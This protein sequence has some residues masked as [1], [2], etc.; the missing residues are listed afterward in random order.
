[1]NIIVVGIGNVGE[2]ITEQLAKE[3]HNLVVVDKDP[4]I[5]NRTVEDYDVKGVYGN[6]A[7]Y[8]VL[9][10]A[11][12]SSADLLV[13]CTQYDEMNI[14]SCLVAK[15]LGVKE[16]IA[17]I[18]NS[19][20]FTLFMSAE[21]GINMM[22]SPEYQVAKE[23]ARLLRFPS[24]IKIEPFAGGKV[25]L[26]ELRIKPESPLNGVALH[27]LHSKLDLDVLVCAVM[28]QND[29]FIPSGNFTLLAGDRI[30]VTAS[31]KILNKFFTSLGLLKGSKKVMVIGG[32]RTASFLATELEK[33]DMRVKII[34]KDE[35]KCAR[36]TD[37]LRKTEVVL[38][39]G[40]DW[41][42]LEDE[43]VKSADA[44]VCLC[45]LDEQNVIMSLLIASANVG[46]VIAKVEK[47]TYYGMLTSGGVDSI[48]STKSSTA[49]EIVRYARNMDGGRHG[50]SVDR[51]YRI[52]ND[53]AEALEFT[54]HNTFKALGKPLK[55]IRFAQNT[56]IGGIIRNGNF[57]TPRGNDTIEINDG[58]IV[59]TTNES[60][61]ELNDI[62][63]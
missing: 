44:V 8:E 35:A 37:A 30:Y 49:E 9:R 25:D 63:E 15:K 23:I 34:E 54:V 32:S 45:G 55:D 52:V 60:L 27:E 47:N 50:G 59:I 58:L 6:G 12:V 57:I 24:A 39:D 43:G 41:E 11:G 33:L 1:M 38:G 56:L 19:E 14:L 2:E 20:Y 5:V 3:G 18:R 22:V 7:S 13:A 21:L 42:V 36:L 26:V 53:R 17:R 61:S 46:K 16:T 4:A 48:V 62:L 31:D 40:T 29:V 51:L 10:E 28:R